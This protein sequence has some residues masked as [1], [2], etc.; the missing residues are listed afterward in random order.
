MDKARPSRRAL[1][2]E[3]TMR[4]RVWIITI[5]LVAALSA[6]LAAMAVETRRFHTELRKA[7]LDFNAQ[8][9]R[10]GKGASRPVSESAAGP[11]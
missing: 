4:R 2:W 1:I 8:A 10:R 3:Q 6:W 5:G 7:R 11:R 9:L